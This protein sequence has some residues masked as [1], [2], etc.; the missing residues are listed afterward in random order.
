MC[1]GPV[2][3][4]SMGDIN[5]KLTKSTI[6]KPIVLE[7]SDVAVLNSKHILSSNKARVILNSISTLVVVLLTIQLLLI[8]L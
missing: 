8:L 2:I 1:V 6:H 7:G 5:I 4:S 3:P